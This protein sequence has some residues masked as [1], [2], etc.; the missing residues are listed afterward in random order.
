MGRKFRITVDIELG[1]IVDG[2]QAYECDVQ[3]DYNK[4]DEMVIL[5]RDALVSLFHSI[6]SDMER[7]ER[8]GE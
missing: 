7:A 6:A 5:N 4:V 8:E 3:V 1:D 2:K